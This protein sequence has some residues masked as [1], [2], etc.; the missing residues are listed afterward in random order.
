MLIDWRSDSGRYKILAS[1]FLVELLECC[2]GN[3]SY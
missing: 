1:L 3:Q 2:D